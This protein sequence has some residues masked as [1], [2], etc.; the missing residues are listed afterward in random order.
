MVDVFGL[1]FSMNVRPNRNLLFCNNATNFSYEWNNSVI[2]RNNSHNTA[3]FQPLWHLI[4]LSWYFLNLKW[5]PESSPACLQCVAYSW[6]SCNP[7][8]T[9]AINCIMKKLMCIIVPNNSLQQLSILHVR[10]SVGL[11]HTRNYITTWLSFPG[12]HVKALCLHIMINWVP[13]PYHNMS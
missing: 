6:R 12:V 1:F 9:T 4:Q 2:M 8:Q 13:I 3:Q 10:P 11:N 5:H 7:G